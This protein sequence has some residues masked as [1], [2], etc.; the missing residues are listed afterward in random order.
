M[1]ARRPGD[2]GLTAQ[3]V[4]GPVRLWEQGSDSRGPSAGGRAAGTNGTQFINVL[5]PA[6]H[7]T[8]CVLRWS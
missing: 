5:G 1:A 7:Y 6:Q 2:E 4:W 8:C 3:P